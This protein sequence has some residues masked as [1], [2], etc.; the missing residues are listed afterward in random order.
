MII[1]LEDTWID[2]RTKGW[3]DP[4]LQDSFGNSQGSNKYNCTTTVD[5]HLKVK[6]IDY[7]TSLTKNIASQSACK[8]SA[9]LTN[10]VLRYIRFWGL[11]HLMAVSIFDHAHYAKNQLLIIAVVLVYY[12]LYFFVLNFYCH[13]DRCL[14][15]QNQ[16]WK[17]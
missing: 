9:Q 2:A 7:N 17:H 16:H 3:T 6:D 10:S 8:K 15:V 11:V 13:S 1:F 12:N 4:I 14:P 5:C